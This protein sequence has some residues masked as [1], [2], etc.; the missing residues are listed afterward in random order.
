MKSIEARICS[1]ADLY[2]TLGRK[3]TD[4]VIAAGWIQP[5]VERK[6]AAGRSLCIYAIE[7]LRRAEARILNGEYPEP[8]KNHK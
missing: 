7:D 5:R 6:G 2:R 8:K 3:I 1:Q 4:D